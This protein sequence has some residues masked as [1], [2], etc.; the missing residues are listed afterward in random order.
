MSK[1]EKELIDRIRLIKILRAWDN[2]SDLVPQFVWDTINSME[3]ENISSVD[4]NNHMCSGYVNG[5]CWGRADKAPTDCGGDLYKCSFYTHH[6]LSE[7]YE[8]K[9]SIEKENER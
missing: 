5:C 4:S 3:Q 9:K 2:N 6:P 8:L 1:S 7:L